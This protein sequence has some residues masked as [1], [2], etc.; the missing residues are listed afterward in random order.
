MVPMK[1]ASTVPMREQDRVG[2][3]RAVDVA[4]H[5]N[6]ARDREQGEQQQDEGDVFEERR[7]GES[8]DRRRRP[9]GERHGNEHQQAPQGGDLALMMLPDMRRQKREQG[10][11]QKDA[12]EGQGPGDAEARPVELRRE[13]CLGQECQGGGQR[14]AWEAK[15]VVTDPQQAGST[16]SFFNDCRNAFMGT[17]LTAATASAVNRLFTI[18]QR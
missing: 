9:E 15:H 18:S 10:D 13:G 11:R 7:M 1:L 12:D 6:A 16:G 4:A 3:R 2:A 8:M 14:Q 5:E 17:G